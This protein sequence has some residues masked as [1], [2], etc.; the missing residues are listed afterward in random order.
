MGEKVF[1][2]EEVKKHDSG[3]DCWCVV[4]NK[5]Y[6]VTEFLAEHPGGEEILLETAGT[7]ST[8]AFEDVGHSQDARTLLEDYYIGELDPKDHKEY[9]NQYVYT[10]SNKEGGPVPIIWV[11]VAGCLAAGVYWFMRTSA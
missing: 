4:H 1:T 5:V 2:L 9:K 3:K 7:D 11:I 8:E 10:D 6:D